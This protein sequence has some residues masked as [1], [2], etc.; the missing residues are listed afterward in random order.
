MYVRSLKATVTEEDVRRVFGKYG[1]IQSLVLKPFT[2]QNRN[3]NPQ[4]PE[5]QPTEVQLQ[6]G[7]I[8]FT[9]EDSGTNLLM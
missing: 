9:S 1:E 2:R 5:Q 7:F 6:F 3:P 4:T 8:N